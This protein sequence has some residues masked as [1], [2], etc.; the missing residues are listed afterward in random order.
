MASK[1][2]R[3][4]PFEVFRL[5]QDMIRIAGILL[6][7]GQIR[8]PLFVYKSVFGALIAAFFASAAFADVPIIPRGENFTCTPTHVWDGD[9]PVWCSEGPRLRLA[10]IAA[11]EL[12]GS[13]SSGHP[14]PAVSG[15]EGRDALVDLLGAQTGVGRHGHILINGPTLHCRSDGPAGGNRT[16]SWCA[17]GGLCSGTDTGATIAARVKQIKKETKAVTPGS[18]QTTDAAG[19]FGRARR[20]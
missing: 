9:G 11:R 16:A 6:R 4:G 1:S 5:L 2:R 20:Q 10:G 15:I 12:D 18:R 3:C 19:N 14:C 8:V 7:T 17:V 13:C